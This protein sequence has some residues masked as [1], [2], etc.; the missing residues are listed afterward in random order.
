MCCIIL[1]DRS[2]SPLSEQGKSGMKNHVLV[3][4][5]KA[6]GDTHVPAHVTPV[7]CCRMYLTAQNT[8]AGAAQH[9]KSPAHRPEPSFIFKHSGCVLGLKYIPWLVLIQNQWDCWLEAQNQPPK[10][11]AKKRSVWRIFPLFF[12]DFHLF[13]HRTLSIIKF[14]FQTLGQLALSRALRA[15]CQ[16]FWLKLQRFPETHIFPC[17][18]ALCNFLV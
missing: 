6:G 14:L 18:T 13:I 5:Q 11:W 16:I 3:P 7:L 10:S 9:F 4:G 8:V 2:W 17:A 12:H 1:L 15:T